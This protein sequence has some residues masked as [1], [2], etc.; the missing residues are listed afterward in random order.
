MNLY[1]VTN[2]HHAWCA[3]INNNYVSSLPLE[4]EINLKFDLLSFER[5]YE[6]IFVIENSAHVHYDK[7]NLIIIKIDIKD[8]EVKKLS[9]NGLFYSALTRYK[10]ISIYKKDKF[11]RL[12]L[13]G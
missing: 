13:L 1:L 8:D 5:A 12:F 6:R 3:E 2:Y 11:K 10:V 4:S 7:D 9:A